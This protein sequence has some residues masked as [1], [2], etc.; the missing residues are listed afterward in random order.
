MCC[1]GW[2]DKMGPI[3]YVGDTLL[4]PIQPRHVV[5]DHYEQHVKNCK[6]CQEGLGLL[7]RI[8]RGL[9]VAGDGTR[10]EG[11]GEWGGWGWEET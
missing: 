1:R 7:R 6:T 5:L 2:F 9:V 4:G 8:E 11:S 10:G 3:P